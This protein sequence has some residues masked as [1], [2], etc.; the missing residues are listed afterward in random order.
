M[1]EVFVAFRL[2]YTIWIIGSL[3]HVSFQS[4][5]VML[6]ISVSSAS[7]KHDNCVKKPLQCNRRIIIVIIIIIAMFMVL[8]LW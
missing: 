5:L 4:F 2:A 8:S 3:F 1:L 6:R 7:S